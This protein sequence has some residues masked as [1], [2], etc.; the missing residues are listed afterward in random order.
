[1]SP[2]NNSVGSLFAEHKD[3]KSG[4]NDDFISSCLINERSCDPFPTI[5]SASATICAIVCISNFSFC[6][7]VKIFITP[8]TT[9]TNDLPSHNL[10]S[11]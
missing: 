7:S 5:A 3:L 4:F 11:G 2:N 10:F 8:A 6:T 1:M 9:L